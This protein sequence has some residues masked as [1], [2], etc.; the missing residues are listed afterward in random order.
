LGIVSVVDG[1]KLLLLMAMAFALGAPAAAACRRCWITASIRCKANRR[2]LRIC[3][4][5]ILVVN[6]ASKCG[7]TPQFDKLEALYKRYRGRGL[8]VIGFPS[9][10]FNQELATNK[11]I[12]SFCRLTYSVEFR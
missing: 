12:A 3:K 9:N 4:P 1:F 8:L 10:D 7:Y 6:T 2:S 11:E 5:P